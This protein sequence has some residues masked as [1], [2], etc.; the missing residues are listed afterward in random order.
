MP[1]GVELNFVSDDITL[2]G[3]VRL[4]RPVLEREGHGRQSDR[5]PPNGK[6]CCLVSVSTYHWNGGKGATPGR[7]GIIGGAGSV[8]PVQTKSG[9]GSRT[10][11]GS[12]SPRAD[13]RPLL[14]G[15]YTCTD[16]DPSTWSSNDASSKL[17]FCRVFVQVAEK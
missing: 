17:G 3:L 13:A 16:S 7:I 11:T 12:T 6:A 1:E 15:S 2:G 9:T 14:L 4:G 5:E 8:G 10:R